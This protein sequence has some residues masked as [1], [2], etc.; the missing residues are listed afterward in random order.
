MEKIVFSDQ[1]W[2]YLEDNYV[3]LVQRYDGETLMEYSDRF[4]QEKNKMGHG[5]KENFSGPQKQF[6][7][8]EEMK[9]RISNEFYSDDLHKSIQN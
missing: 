1:S 9:Q 3:Q 7:N 6:N 4:S 8:I 5:E 2:F